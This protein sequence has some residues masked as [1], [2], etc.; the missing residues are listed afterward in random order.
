MNKKD[1]AK[2]ILNK[3]PFRKAALFAVGLLVVGA[4]GYYGIRTEEQGK[5]ATPTH[6]LPFDMPSTA[7]LRSSP[8]KV[9]AHYFPPYPISLDN[10]DP[11]TDYYQRHYLNANGEN[12]KFLSVG[13]LLRQRPLPSQP[14]T[15][16]A[17]SAGSTTYK[18]DDPGCYMYKHMQTEVRNAIKGG[19]DGFTVDILGTSDG[20]ANWERTKSLLAACGSVDPGFKIML[21]PDGNGSGV[22]AGYASLATKM[23]SLINDAKYNKCIFKLGDGRVVISPF[24]AEGPGAAYW[25][26]FISS[27]QS[28]GHTVAFVPTFLNYGANA[29]TFAPFSYG[30]SNWGNRNP[31]HNSNLGANIKDAHARGKIWM[32]PVSLQDERPNQAI[33]DESQNTDNYRITWKAAT[34]FGA[35][36]IQIPTWNDYSEGTE[37]APSTHTGW[38]PL[39]IGAYYLIKYK[40]GAFPPIVRDT[41]YVSHRIQFANKLPDPS[42]GTTNP[43]INRGVKLN[44]SASPSRDKVEVL[45]FLT[46]PATVRLTINGIDQ[47]LSVPAGVTP[48]LFNLAS[49]SISAKVERSGQPVVSVASPFAVKSTFLKQDEQYHFVSSGREGEV[50]SQVP[51]SAPDL[52]VTSIS[53]SPVNPTVGSPTTFSA[54]VKNQGTAATPVGTVTGVSFKVNG[55]Q[56]SWSDTHTASL[57]PGASVT[58]TANSGPSGQSTWT[59]TAGSHMLSA[60]VDDVNR[61]SEQNEL[62]NDLVKQIVVADALPDVVVTSII[63]NPSSPTA[64][65]AT[66]FSA[67]VKNQGAGA[68]PAGVIVGVSFLVNGTQV[69]W[70]DT[71][72][73]GLSPGASVMLTANSGPAGTSTWTATA[74]TQTIAAKVDD[75]NRIAESDELNNTSSRQLTVSQTVTGDVNGDGR[76]NA[77]DLSLVLSKDGTNDPRADLNRDGVVGAADMA[78]LLSKWTW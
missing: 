25:K 39:D 41:I 6:P 26:S 37:I 5:A 54:V 30:F 66:R 32:Q 11:A 65:T 63:S 57:A 52:V 68:V 44:N 38:S 40:T 47:T 16:V 15:S 21:M 45:S 3:F 76:V 14:L 55:V 20:N 23:S 49:G 19:L 8:R 56:V 73:A 10:Q 22:A 72:V 75:V 28:K 4:I 64:G 31:A 51:Q 67:V 27:M 33:Y 61:I 58:L 2:L 78:I 13:G 36:W 70:S 42:G 43:M 24:K 48:S 62:N 46:A 71:H 59:A 17:C 1:Q 9:F 50:Y 29:D 12:G 35:E 34:D 77:I 74:G 53:S 69:S 7:S 60:K 18:F